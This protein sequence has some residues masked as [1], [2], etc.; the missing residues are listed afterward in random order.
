MKPIDYQQPSKLRIFTAFYRPH[1]R[2][3]ALDMGC[4]TAIA[5]IDLVF[6]LASRYA[7][8]NLLP[9][10]IYSTFF[11]LMGSLLAMYL[12]RGVLNYIVT[13]WG[14]TLG[15]R[16]EA[17]MR[18]DL[19]S[20]LQSLPF[21]FYDKH[22]TGQLMSRVTTDLF[23]ITEL[24][25]HG[26][27][28][29]FLS[30]ITLVGSFAV[31]FTIH[32]QLA[33]VLL[34]LVPLAL[35]FTISQRRRMSG[36][37]RKVKERMA[38]I[39][40]DIESA[41]SGARVAKAFTNEDYEIERFAVGNE[42][43]KTAKGGF[44]SSMA[45]FHSG[46][47]L[48]ANVFN[49]LV[50][51]VGGWFMMRGSMDIN[52]LVVFILYVSTFLSPIRRLTAFV[53]QYAT[54]MAGFSRFLELM[55]IQPDITDTSD[56]TTLSAV[57]GRIDFNDVT[58]AYDE[59]QNVLEH[60]SLHV[61]PGKMLALVGPSGAGKTTLCHL[62]PRFYDST[63]GTITIDGHDIR[64]VTLRSLRQNV[65]IVSQEVFLFAG[66]VREN[67]AY[68]RVDA[69]ESEIVDAAK[70]AEI[71]ESILEMPDGL[72]TYVGERG[73]RLSGGQKQRIA[74][75]RIFLKNPPIL[76]LDEATS[77]LDTVTER[78]IQASFDQLAKG[79]TTFVIAHRLSTVERADEI[80][81]IDKQGIRERGTHQ[82]L[83]AADGLY[84]A[85]QR[86]HPAEKENDA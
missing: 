71:Y 3:F 53:E 84:A 66:T 18:R 68:G 49:V 67:I 33:L 78:R 77:A 80:I 37:S 86:S 9:N 85:L 31:L 34:C 11:V 50:V 83:M 24:A 27:E 10:S 14:H 4:A 43:F 15:V 70:R 25:H 28:D 55:R 42:Q 8:N 40:A 48:M 63:S 29:L 73:M 76:L 79:R 44:Y 20:H 38:A 39:N 1:A 65:G 81:Y 47:E 64:G 17:N 6:P 58:F 51:A 13:Y 74:I 23:E 46:I 21:T 32:W 35:L 75:A 19:F 60:L 26:P 82:Q 59:S 56:A 45:L 72:D 5:L 54:G 57:Q 41:I 12:L 16:M 22:R 69:T 61:E 30:I 62:I 7:L 52:D 36:S 2:L